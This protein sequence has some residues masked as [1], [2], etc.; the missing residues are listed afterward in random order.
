VGEEAGLIQW[1]HA[2]DG[3]NASSKWQVHGPAEV[4]ECF[5]GGPVRFHEN[6][7]LNLD[8]EIRFHAA[9]DLHRFVSN[10][11]DGAG[12][13][14]NAQIAEG[15]ERDSYHLRIT[16]K[17]EEAK[18][19]LHERYAEDPDARFGLVA[20]SR[21]RDLERFGIANGFAATRNFRFG[22]WYGD[23]ESEP[24]ERS[25][26]HLT[27]CVTEFGAQGL[28]LDAVLLAWGTDLQWDRSSWSSRKARRYQRVG[29][30]RDPHQLR[31]NAYRVLLTRGR[32]A[33]VVFAPELDE[34]D[35]TYEYLM[36]SGF[37]LL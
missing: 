3:S 10:L 5:S 33:A 28:E 21:D 15:L 14:R 11:L 25:C 27:D 22:P 29:R 18:A 23:S 17:L 6:Q 19:Y 9:R 37:R 30:V 16:R 35:A 4:R 13:A 20:S 34:M 32:D 36:A 31:L 8:T 12:P 2:I 26:R 1:R 24:G 7:A